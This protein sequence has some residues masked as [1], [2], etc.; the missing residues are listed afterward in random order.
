MVFKTTADKLQRAQEDLSA[1]ES[2][3]AGLRAE[4]EKLIEDGE[5]ETFEKIDRR[6]A[7]RE[8]QADVF[9]QRIPLL[10]RRLDDEQR[11]AVRAKRE[12][13]IAQAEK[14][15]PIRMMAV[16]AIA[17]WARDGVALVDRLQSAT[18]LKGWPPGLERP[19]ASNVN[20]EQFLRAISGALSGIGAAD[21]TPAVAL[22]VIADAVA[23]QVENHMAAV[24]DLRDTVARQPENSEAAA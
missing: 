8:R 16:E 18:K 19:Y 14:I 1:T 9:R 21:W 6:I 11:A 15:L 2:V 24:D 22:D 13:A 3:I 4:R 7:D 23:I 20:N 10:Q 5:P 12:E 17:K